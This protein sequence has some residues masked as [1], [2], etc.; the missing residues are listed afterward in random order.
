MNNFV[1]SPME[2]NSF[3]QQRLIWRL[4]HCLYKI[5]HCDLDI[6]NIQPVYSILTNII[7]SLTIAYKAMPKTLNRLQASIEEIEQLTDSLATATTKDATAAKMNKLKKILVA[8]RS[9]L[10]NESTPKQNYN[11]E[12]YYTEALEKLATEKQKLEDT[13]KEQNSISEKQKEELT[14]SLHAVEAQVA[15]LKKEKQELIKQKDAQET[16][17]TQIKETFKDL[18]TYIKPIEDEQKRLNVLYY[19][20]I[21]GEILSLVALAASIYFF[22][23]NRSAFV[24]WTDCIP[25]YLPISFCAA[26]LWICIFQMNRAQRQLIIIAN[27]LHRIKYIEGLLLAI[28]NL[29][30]DVSEGIA[31]I[32]NVI[33]NIIQNYLQSNESLTEASL[34]QEIS[35]DKLS[36]KEVLN[37]MKESKELFTK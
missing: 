14:N 4:Q 8:I 25:F 35:K 5:E 33:N 37:F 2:T 19:G 28:N 27:Q 13:L 31:T 18:Q 3:M 36:L 32:K 1:L 21:I 12:N 7:S 17:K 9:T 16:L 23:Q 34:Q 15:Q 29:S 6:E 30:S 20:Y 10:H 22:I 24:K 11:S 26:V